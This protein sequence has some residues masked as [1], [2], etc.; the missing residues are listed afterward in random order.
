MRVT[1]DSSQFGFMQR[2]KLRF[3]LTDFPPQAAAQPLTHDHLGIRRRKRCRGVTTA[4][5]AHMDPSG[6]EALSLFFHF[7][8]PSYKILQ[9]HL[10]SV[11]LKTKQ[12][13]NAVV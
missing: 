7:D 4:S 13:I 3:S 9:L 5:F 1:R 11:A 10:C 8:T 2:Q 12:N 6:C